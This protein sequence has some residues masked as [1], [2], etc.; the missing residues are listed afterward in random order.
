MKHNI[1][2]V[3]EDL[4][5]L[6]INGNETTT[7]GKRDYFFRSPI[8]DEAQRLIK[9]NGLEGTYMRH[10]STGHCETQNINLAMLN[11]AER[12]NG[13]VGITLEGF[14]RDKI[15]NWIVGYPAGRI[16]YEMLEDP[17]VFK[18]SVDKGIQIPDFTDYL[19]VD[20]WDGEKII[21]EKR[22]KRANKQAEKIKKNIYIELQP[23]FVANLGS[24]DLRFGAFHM[25]DYRNLVEQAKKNPPQLNLSLREK[26]LDLLPV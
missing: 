22:C 5:W 7:R 4:R 14:S 15:A 19:G 2:I 13:I 3:G 1:N 24:I 11:L 16:L 10:L 26:V 9:E 8:T 23:E 17:Y 6:D 21:Q 12:Y 25:E 20:T 18:V